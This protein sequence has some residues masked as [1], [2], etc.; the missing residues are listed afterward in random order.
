MFEQ[1]EHSPKTGAFSP[2]RTGTNKHRKE[3]RVM[4]VAFDRV[5]RSA[6]N[7]V[8]KGH[9][10]RHHNGHRIGFTVRLNRSDDI[11]DQAVV[12]TFVQRWPLGSLGQRE[13]IEIRL[14]R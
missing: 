9:H 4:A 10:E 2:F 11:A 7:C 1:A 12:G 14:V 3:I 5:M 6:A 13:S 8:A